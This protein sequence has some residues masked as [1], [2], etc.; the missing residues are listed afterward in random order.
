MKVKTS[1]YLR[2]VSVDINN[3][4]VCLRVCVSVRAYV[5]VRACTCVRVRTC[6]RAYERTCV[7]AEGPGVGF[8][9]SKTKWFR[10]KHTVI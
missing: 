9:S 6:V 5:S 3:A 1:N 2:R 8:R 4:C 7:R 10:S